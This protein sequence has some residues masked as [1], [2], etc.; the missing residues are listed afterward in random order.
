MTGSPQPDPPEVALHRSDLT[1]SPHPDP[2]ESGHHPSDPRIVARQHL[3]RPTQIGPYRILEQLGEGGMGL[4]YLAEQE[5]PIHRRVALKVIKLGMDT[6]EVIARFETEREA[7]ALMSHPNVAKVFDAGSTS[8]GRPYFAMEYVPGV[9]IAEYCD[10]HR[11]NT[12][13]RLQLFMDVCEAVQHAHQKGIIHR[14]L[15]PSNVLV[16]VQDNKP[17]VKVIDFGVAKATQHRLTERTIFTEQGQL[18][19]TPG[20]MSPEQASLT[21]LDVDTRTDIYALGVLLYELLAGARPFDDR[22]LREAGLA[23]IQ[24]I[25]R[26]VDPPKPSTRFSSLGADSTLVAHN[27]RTE[28]RTLARELRGDLDWIVMKCLEK[29]RTRRYA[30]ANGLALEIRRHL[31]DEPVL[32]GPPRVT[33]RMR[34]FVRRNRAT[35]GATIVLFATVALAGYFYVQALQVVQAQERANLFA[36]QAKSLQLNGKHDL[37]WDRC[38]AA[39]DL[40][41]DNSLALRT[42][43][44]LLLWERGDFQA[45]LEAYDKGL[46]PLELAA[47]DFHNRAR[48]RRIVGQWSLALEDHDTAIALAPRRG[49]LYA[50]RAMTQRLRGE[51]DLAIEDLMKAWELDSTWALQG[52]LWVW[53]MRM[54]RG[55]P[56]DSD[57]AATALAQAQS[58]KTGDP[59]DQLYVE[60]CRGA[61]TPEQ[62]LNR[63]GTDRQRFFAYYYLGAKALVDGHRVEAGDWFRQCVASGVRRAQEFDLARWHLDQLSSQ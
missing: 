49:T 4:V 24:R 54:L 31:N 8:D 46:A 32:A 12:D 17:V 23:E 7:L 11:L 36:K 41:P 47:E 42:K 1:G 57:A 3:D 39:L 20:Y 28:P 30:T 10:M 48:L 6:K 29:D 43:A 63:C 62:G 14:D 19:G 53:E 18:V 21:A 13:E 59:L 2:A 56:G 16:M 15:K 50:S 58:A 61:A 38:Q 22:V 37:A 27:R 9:S 35:V 26:E 44:F 55:N 60:I 34:K 51:V 40:D 25:I 33:Y 5:K 45:A 52:N